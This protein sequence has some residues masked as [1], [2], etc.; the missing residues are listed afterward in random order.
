MTCLPIA[1]G[2][3]LV[4]GLGGCKEQ[5][6]SEF[7]DLGNTN[8]SSEPPAGLLYP[9]EAGDTAAI[10]QRGA[11]LFAMERALRLG[12]EQGAFAVGVSEGDTILPLVDIDPGGRSGQV[13]F[14]RWKKSDKEKDGRLLAEHA[15]RWLLVPLMLDPERVIDRELITGKIVEG[16]ADFHRIRAL[17][18][19]AEALQQRTPEEVYH[20]FTVNEVMAT[21]EKKKPSKVVTRVYAMSADGDGPD[22]EVLV[23]APKRKRAPEVLAVETIHEA[24]AAKGSPIRV[25]L[26][27]P[28]PATVV[29]AMLEGPDAGD[30]PVQGN[31]GVVYA[32]SARNGRITRP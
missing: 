3:A 13:V 17:L 15:E 28:G 25:A 23:D 5:P 11:L 20:L 31:G 30:V 29:R 21:G 9:I 12:Y 24:G 32:V 22:L 4:L 8:A 26:P 10:E 14:V 6:D 27:Q 19:A 2:I 16:S 1:V 7:P 18:A